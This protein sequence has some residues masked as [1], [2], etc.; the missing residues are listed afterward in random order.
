[1]REYRSAPQS[2]REYRSAPQS[3]REYR[4]APQSVREYRSAPQSVREYRSAPKA[5]QVVFFKDW[6]RQSASRVTGKNRGN[7]VNKYRE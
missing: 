4:S 7:R 3:V 6:C 2:V 5:Q 1:V